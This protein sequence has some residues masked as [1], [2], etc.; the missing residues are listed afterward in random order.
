MLPYLLPSVLLNKESPGTPVRAVLPLTRG[1]PDF[2]GGLVR[3]TE[4]Q[5]QRARQ[6]PQL[7]FITTVFK[8][9]YDR[10]KCYG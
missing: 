10:D 8:V 3:D 6:V 7:A 5:T 2:R 1:D 9:S 4:N